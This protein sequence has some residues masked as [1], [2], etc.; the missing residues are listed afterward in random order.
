[1]PM[2]TTTQCV[3]LATASLLLEN[4]VRIGGDILILRKTVDFVS[5]Y[6]VTYLLSNFMTKEISRL[7][8]GTT[9]V[10]QYWK[11]LKKMEIKIPPITYQQWIV[12]FLISIYYE[13]RYIQREIELNKEFKRSLLSKMFC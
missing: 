6:F 7:A 10:H 9:I 1:M 5:E 8:Q 3:D 13:I 4:N 2:S 12:N 11:Y